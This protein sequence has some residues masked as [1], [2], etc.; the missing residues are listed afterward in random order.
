MDILSVFGIRG[1][2]KQVHKL[3]DAMNA[4]G[5]HPKRVPDAV[6]LAAL[7]LFKEAEGGKMADVDASCARAAPLLVYC[8]LGSEDF[9]KTNG[10]HETEQ[11]EARIR[12]AIENGE[13][14]DAHLAMLTLLANVI[15]PNVKEKYDLQIDQ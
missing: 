15:H 8:M 13:S 7:K 5:L 11:V 3:E 12:F 9:A 2:P 4:L 10:P 6:K 14:L 1:R